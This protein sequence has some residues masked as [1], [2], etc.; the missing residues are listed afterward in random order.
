MVLSKAT[1]FAQEPGSC[2]EAPGVTQR[3]GGGGAGAWQGERGFRTSGVV[4]T[5]GWVGGAD[6]AGVA[7]MGGAHTCPPTP[8]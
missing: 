4:E 1:E 6:T 2:L 7:V 3:S 8:L 5:D